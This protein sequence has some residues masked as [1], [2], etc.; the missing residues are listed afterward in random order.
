MKFLRIAFSPEIFV[1][2]VFM[3]RFD[4]KVP[5]RTFSP[6]EEA[7]NCLAPFLVSRALRPF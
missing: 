5:I 3:L 4:G 7:T 2:V 6:G 1:F